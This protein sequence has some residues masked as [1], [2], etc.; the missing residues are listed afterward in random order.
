MP[1]VRVRENEPF[2]VAMRRFKRACE[3][4]G[5]LA[6][7]HRR[8]YYEKPSVRRKRKQAEARRRGFFVLTGS[9][10]T[11][12]DAQPLLDEMLNRRVDGLL[13]LNPRD[14]ERY[15]YLLPLV[16]LV[17]TEAN[18]AEVIAEVEE[19]SLVWKG[20]RLG[21][22]GCEQDLAAPGGGHDAGG[23][24]DRWP[25]IV[26]LCRSCRGVELG[27]AGVEAGADAVH[28]RLAR[29]AQALDDR[30]RIGVDRFG[31]NTVIFSRVDICLFNGFALSVGAVSY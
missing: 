30:L 16:E 22:L 28:V 7:V 23:G 31:I 18:P 3:K 24:V 5:V 8:E 27:F 25:E 14:D 19:G 11:A 29:A 9:A 20:R 15:T 6:E 21:H 13:V 2:E 1:T 4:A 10:P 17:T 12:A 26:P